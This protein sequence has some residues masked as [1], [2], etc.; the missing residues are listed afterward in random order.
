MDTSHLHNKRALLISQRDQLNANLN[1]T[2]GAIAMVDELLGDLAAE[3]SRRLTTEAQLKE[4]AQDIADEAAH[5]AKMSQMGAPP[6]TAELDCG[7][8]EH[9]FPSAPEILP[10]IHEDEAIDIS[11]KRTGRAKF[12]GPKVCEFPDCVCEGS[13]DCAA[14]TFSAPVSDPA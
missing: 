6:E 10:V 4:A 5:T 12:K 7:L 2:L 13:D 14:V 3:E 11:P 8:H 1:A 9:A